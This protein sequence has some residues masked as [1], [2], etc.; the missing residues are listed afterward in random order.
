MKV[1]A[2]DLGTNTFLCL[3][4]EGNET[5]IT[6]VHKDLV[7]VVRL[8]QGVD[9]TGELQDEALD[10]ARKCLTEFKKEIDKHHVD[11]ILAMATS[12][13][14]DAR[15]G[16]ELFDIG[17][18]LGIPIEVIPGEDEARISY[19][20]ATGGVIEPNK[21]NLVVDVGGGSTELIV[22][23]GE[24]ILF[25]ESLNIGGVRLTEKF[26]TQQPVSPRE[27]EQLSQY[28][29]EQIQKILPDLQKNKLDQIIAV[30]GTPTSIVAIEVG[31]FDEK[32]V[33]GFFLSKERLKF[34]VHEFSQTSVEEKRTKYQLGGRADIIF[35]GASILLNVV[36]A[37]NMDGIC[38]STKGVRYGVALEMLRSSSRS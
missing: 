34:W 15:N 24:E 13:A 30:A 19:Q 3:I 37:L 1:A 8:G 23:R 11:K 26:V 29:N 5:G 22:G 17:K 6:K 33:D 7:E 25:G 16:Q 28:I 9:K 4:A 27:Q 12:A 14:R 20:G 10:R 35:A 31:G 36:E 18:E 21:T 38:V 32:K 2:L